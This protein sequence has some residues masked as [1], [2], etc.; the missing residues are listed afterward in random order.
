M[1]NR[2][3]G[4]TPETPPIVTV[5]TP[6]HVPP[7]LA[8]PY[9]V[10]WWCQPCSCSS[11]G[12]YI[13]FLLSFRPF[14]LRTVILFVLVSRLSSWTDSERLRRSVW[15]VFPT[16]T[17]KFLFPKVL[18]TRRGGCHSPPL[19]A[20]VCIFFFLGGGGGKGKREG[21]VHTYLGNQ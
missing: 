21:W 20:A 10:V 19:R 12:P 1:S 15:L 13:L 18:P 14:F 5:P 8:R 4:S 3:P 6:A 2:C 17:W 11:S 7:A 16:I 9:G